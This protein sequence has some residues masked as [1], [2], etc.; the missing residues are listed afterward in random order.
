MSKFSQLSVTIGAAVVLALLGGGVAQAVPTVPFATPR[1]CLQEFED[2]DDYVGDGWVDV[3]VARADGVHLGCGDE[4][5]G[6]VH[7]GSEDSH[8]HTHPITEAS[9][10]AFVRCFDKLIREGVMS[11]DPDSRTRDRYQLTFYE[12]RDYLPKKATVIVDR[13]RKFVWAM[14]TTNSDFSPRG[15]N[16]SGCDGSALIA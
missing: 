12:P 8:G 11:P 7:I 6:V 5:S 3:P 10:A 1:E 14:Y 16:W 13:E 2:N 9:Q 4:Y 15:N